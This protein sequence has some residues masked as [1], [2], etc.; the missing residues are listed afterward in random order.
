M[1]F[2]KKLSQDP[3]VKRNLKTIVKGSSDAPYSGPDGE[4]EVLLKKFDTFESKE[5]PCAVFT[6]VVDD[7]GDY[8]GEKVVIFHWLGDNAAASFEENLADLCGTLQSLGIQT[9]GRENEF[10][11]FDVEVEKLLKTEPR[12]QIRVVD[13]KEQYPKVSV[14]AALGEGQE[15]PFEEEPEEDEDS[16]QSIGIRADDGDE[17]A[18]A[19]LTEYCEQADIDPDSYDTWEAV[20]NALDALEGVED[21]APEEAE[22]VETEEVEEEPEEDADDWDDEESGGDYSEGQAPSDWVDYTCWYKP[23]RHKAAK[24]FTVTS[25]D[26]ATG[27]VVL[28]G[29]AGVFEDVSVLLIA[30]SQ[31]EA[32]ADDF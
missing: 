23:P 31:E 18:V 32:E 17:D 8:S 9:E 24:E 15:A 4:L 11:Q 29:D 7:G 2:F 25:G 1:S 5:V 14:I 20:G 26:D 16:C 10:D 28:T 30:E 6:F 22:E 27:L 13:A 12:Y 19:E 21:E 3:N